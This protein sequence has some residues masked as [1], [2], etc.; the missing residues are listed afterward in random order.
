[1]ANILKSLAAGVAFGL[2]AGCCAQEKTETAS[3]GWQRG[4]A[5]IL[6]GEWGPPDTTMKLP[7]GNLLYVYG[8]PQSERIMTP[9][10]SVPGQ[11]LYTVTENGQTRYVAEVTDNHR[12]ALDDNGR[13][14]TMWFEAT[15][16]GNILLAGCEGC[17]EEE[18][19][20]LATFRD[21]QGQLRASSASWL[22]KP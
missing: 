20:M 1:M 9:A 19:R 8:E 5:E 12:P 3:N 15:A 21:G 7:S 13:K 16:T 18:N 10:A 11:H 17:S 14:P 6:I 4:D 22:K 2:A